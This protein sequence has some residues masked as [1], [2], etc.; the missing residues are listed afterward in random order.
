M[1][2]AGIT[3]QD[4]DNVPYMVLKGDFPALTPP[5]PRR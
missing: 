2:A 4:F 1:L 3:A 5:A